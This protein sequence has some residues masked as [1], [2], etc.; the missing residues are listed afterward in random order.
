MPMEN[1]QMT[2]IGLVLEGGG[3]RGVYTAGAL[4]YLLD[5]GIF[6]PEI[7]GVSAGACH[8]CSYKSRQRGRAANTVLQFVNN[9][10]YGSFRNLF[11]TGD[12]FGKQ[13]AYYDIPE[14]LLPFDYEFFRSNPQ[15]LTAVVTDVES[16]LPA[17]LE[18][19]DL[20]IDMERLRASS[21]LPLLS[22]MVSIE[23]KK[24]LDGGISDPIPLAKSIAGGNIKNILIL[25]RGERYRMPVSDQKALRFW[26]RKYPAFAQAL[27]SRHKV[28]NGALELVSAEKAAGRA[29]VIR[30]RNE[31]LVGR[32]EKDIQK[33]RALYE[34]G[35]EDAKAVLE[36]GGEFLR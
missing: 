20:K 14:R 11:T 16:G 23:G 29:L 32:L 18:L 27:G 6:L 22:R 3:M 17:Y 34:E 30:P 9:Y 7:Y 13:F 10:R 36:K 31:V 2:G 1:Q 24:Y 5:A 25:T 4:D 28:Y 12:Y 26:Y 8:A 15:K 33:L 21:S 35:Y 19:V